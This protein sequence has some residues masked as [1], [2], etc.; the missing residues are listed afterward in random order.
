MAVYTGKINLIN[1][2]NITATAGVGIQ[3]TEVLYAVAN[4]GSVPPDL[5]DI[6]L[7]TKDGVISFASTGASFQIID[8]I[9]WAYQG[10][11]QVPLTI[12][13]DKILVG[14]SGWSPYIPEEIGPGLYLWTKTIYYY[15]N[16]TEVVVFNVSKQGE[17][18]EQGPPGVSTTSFK[19]ECNQTEILK[20]IDSSTGKI[21][22]SPNVLT[23]SILK[24]DPLSN[25]GFTQIND[26][27]KSKFNIE[28]YD[29]GGGD[30][31]SITDSE[32]I[33]LDN[34]I[35]NIDLQRFI[36]KAHTVENNSYAAKEIKESECVI[37]ISYQLTQVND[38]NEKEY[39]NIVDF[40]N[41]RFGMNKDMASLSIKANGVVAAMQ[42]SKMVFDATG[43]TLQNGAFKIIKT[44][45][46][47]GISTTTP[48]FYTDELGNLVLKG[49]VY[50]ENGSFKGHIEA[51]SGTFSGEL[52]AATG[53]FNGELRGAS[54]S[55][56][57]DISAAT[58]TIGGFRIES[59]R[60]VSTNGELTGELSN[61]VLDGE[62]GSIYANNIT[63]G[64]G[65][66][67]EDYIKIGDQVKLSKAINI[68]DSFISVLNNNNEILALRADGTMKIGNGVNTIILSGIDGSITSQSYNDGLGWKIS[69][70][71]SIFNDVTVKGSIRASVLEYGEVQAIGGA[72]LVRPSTRIL[73]INYDVNNNK[74]FTILTLEEIKDFKVGD[75]CRIDT[76][77]LN[78][79]GAVYYTIINVDTTKKTITFAG[80]LPN[81]VGKPIVNFG[82][83]NDNIG[84]S[85]NGSSDESFCLPRSI[86]VFEFD[87]NNTRV[88]P[89]I[90]LGKLPD[91]KDL[92]GFA[93]GTYGL[94]AENVLLK[95]SLVTQ[96][97]TEDNGLMYSGISTVYSGND[98]PKSEK[99]SSKISGHIPSEILLWAGAQS[100]KAA[101]I[102]ASKF[103]V[104]RNGNM[105]AG[106]G[107][108]EGTIITDATIKASVIE[109]TTIVGYG[110]KPALKIEDAARGIYFVAKDKTTNEETI[111]FEVNKDEIVANVS[112]FTFNS[113]FTIEDNGSLA[114]PNLYVVGQGND[115]D[116]NN[117]L[118]NSA[119]TLDN[120]RI[121][122]IKN[123]NRGELTGII[124]GY[125]DFSNGIGFSP[126]GG[127]E[128]ILTLSNQEVR[129]KGDNTSLYIENSVVY[130]ER[131]EYKPV[132]QEGKIIGYDLYIE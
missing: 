49:T 83:S 72:I 61:I 117:G 108:F 22:I 57:G 3:R 76:Q 58:G 127:A 77:S 51:T 40:L 14:V 112:N 7:T 69:N 29:I 67:I 88:V 38:N 60:L 132:K 42:D 121:N 20:F 122:Y 91:G 123:F 114:V 124:E 119:I 24:D 110:E 43:L 130:G 64:I 5:I 55:F 63:L 95:G 11:Y 129:V 17:N 92:Y 71:N 44:T 128:Q 15:T 100:D 84:I 65:A 53:T 78:Q 80:K 85:I 66:T 116:I 113:N 1:M 106:S 26:L 56:S 105:Y 102:E 6:K 18:G 96:T 4:S 31:Y 103:F 46:Q 13:K 50:A 8:D 9:V 99:L 16:N 111:V 30:W 37:K 47:N 19:F 86:T 62:N 28:V 41:V 107:Y 89:R 68:E 12:D 33:S 101:D 25:I 90:V 59:N 87:S 118:T 93:A 48:L 70:T 98:S 81:V 27:D 45:T 21:L 73:S 54:G 36:D 126:D 23:V 79:A 34:H 39:F 35:F 97:R 74:E 104:D 131:I 75:Y 115:Y 125:I 109:T 2:S 120:K 32:V 10:D 94:Y 52:N 82:Q